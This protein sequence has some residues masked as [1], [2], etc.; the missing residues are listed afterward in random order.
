LTV[1]DVLWGYDD[2]MIKLA[3]QFLPSLLPKQKFGFMERV[4]FEFSLAVSFAQLFLF[5]NN[6]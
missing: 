5:H 1:D 6:H 3:A 2:K 4:S